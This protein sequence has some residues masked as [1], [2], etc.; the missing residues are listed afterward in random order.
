MG[1]TLAPTAP[2]GGIAGTGVTALAQ[3]DRPGPAPEMY[4]AYKKKGEESTGVIGMIDLLK[5]DLA[6]EMQ[7]SEVEEKNDQADYEKMVADSAAKRAADS[8]S[9]AEKQGA[10]A[11]TEAALVASKAEKK[12]KTAEAMA[13]AKYI[14]DLHQE[15]DWLLSNFE[16]RKEAR[17][18][19]IDSLKKA[20]AVLSG[21][22]FSL[23]QTK[24]HKF[25]A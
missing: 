22:D 13:N 12:S 1:G 23:V 3:R 19:E 18:G 9:L 24:R 7:E 2:P 15:C 17:A 16:V 10:K 5:A 11:D 8:K 6:K 20:K 4:G 21:A 14:H 25:L